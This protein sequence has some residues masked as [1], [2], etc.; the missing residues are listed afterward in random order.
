MEQLALLKEHKASLIVLQKETT[1]DT[2]EAIE[3]KL[4][5]DSINIVNEC[6]EFCNMGFDEGS[7]API[8]PESWQYLEPDQLAKRMRLAKANWMPSSDVPHG[9]KMAYATATS[10]IKAR[11]A[12]ESGGKTLHIENAVFPAPAPLGQAD[13]LPVIDVESD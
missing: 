7:G 11:A 4:L 9:I 5:E 10:I 13:D 6:N 1:Q 8:V 2:L 3:N 12:K